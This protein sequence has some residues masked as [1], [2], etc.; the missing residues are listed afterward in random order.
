MRL[1][2][3][4]SRV[5]PFARTQAPRM[6]SIPATKVP[7]AKTPIRAHFWRK[8]TLSLTTRKTGRARTELV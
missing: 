3:S 5:D 1:R 7:T 8:L 6:T 2:G 4:P